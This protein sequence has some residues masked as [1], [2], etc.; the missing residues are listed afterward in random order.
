MWRHIAIVITLILNKF[1]Y[2]TY[3]L[4]GGEFIIVNDANDSLHTDPLKYLETTNKTFGLGYTI[5]YDNN[6]N[7]FSDDT[8]I[9]VKSTTSN[10]TYF[11]YLVKNKYYIRDDKCNFICINP[12]GKVFTSPMRLQHFCKFIIKKIKNKYSI[13]TSSTGVTNTTYRVLKFDVNRNVLKG[14]IVSHTNDSVTEKALFKLTNGPVPYK[15]SCIPVTKVQQKNLDT[16]DDRCNVDKS[17]TDNKKTKPVSITDVYIKKDNLKFYKIR[18]SDSK[19]SSDVY[20]KNVI[21]NNVF[22]IRNVKSCKYLCQNIKCGVYESYENSLDCLINVHQKTSNA[23]FYVRFVSNNY[24][25]SYNETTDSMAFSHNTKGILEFVD[26]DYSDKMVCEKFEINTGRPP[27]EKCHPS[28]LSNSL[29]I[30]LPQLFLFLMLNF[31]R[32]IVE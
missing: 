12:C 4:E 18:F 32:T 29:T 5:N 13:Y 31:N 28:N 3:S 14:K 27:S 22:V 30:N 15:G 24:Y 19:Y 25:L 11:F 26:T 1:C 10:F 6:V 20:I 21:N 9:N 16:S 17:I 2:F 8:S 23:P 7:L